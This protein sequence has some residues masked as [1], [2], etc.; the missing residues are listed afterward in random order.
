[1]GISRRINHF[2]RFW[3]CKLNPSVTSPIPLSKF[4]TREDLGDGIVIDKIDLEAWIMANK[5]Y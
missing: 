1:M 5:D 4:W 3:L 2:L